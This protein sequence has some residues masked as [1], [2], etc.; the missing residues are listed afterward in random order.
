MAESVAPKTRK[1]KEKVEEPVILEPTTLVEQES[2]V[3][4]LTLEEAL[5]QGLL[6]GVLPK[7]RHT[8]IFDDDISQESVQDLINK[9][10]NYD[11]IDLFVTTPGG[12]APAMEAL[13]HYLNLRKDDIVIT[14]TSEI[15][16]AGTFILTDF[17]GE[18]K[19]SEYLDFILFH[20][21]DRLMY[22]GRKSSLIKKEKL[23]KHLKV[24]NKKLLE[25]YRKL[26]LN[27]K[28]LKRFKAGYDVVLYRKDFHRLKLKRDEE[29]VLLPPQ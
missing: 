28:E 15:C 16:S 25:K 3:I 24:L 9:L 19:Y 12:E 22:S 27:E 20:S 17:E 13:L 26:G 4:T 7:N 29:Q 1:R 5:E 2:E 6:D 14:L 10:D 8:I 11:L 18:I 21:I 23:L